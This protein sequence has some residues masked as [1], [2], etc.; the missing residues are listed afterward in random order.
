MTEIKFQCIEH[1]YQTVKEINFGNEITTILIN[2]QSFKYNIGL[3]LDCGCRYIQENTQKMYHL[4]DKVK[5]K[6]T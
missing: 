4:N 3:I 1:G 5:E 6:K 2:E